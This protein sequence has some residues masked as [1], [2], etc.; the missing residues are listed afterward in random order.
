MASPLQPTPGLHSRQSHPPFKPTPT[1]T[2][3]PKSVTYVLE[4]KVLPMWLTGPPSDHG[5]RTTDH[6]PFPSR[7]PT[8]D[9]LRELAC[10]RALDLLAGLLGHLGPAASTFLDAAVGDSTAPTDLHHWAFEPV[11]DPAVPTTD[12]RWPRNPIDR[13]ILARLETEG[14]PSPRPPAPNGPARSPT[15]PGFRPTPGN[16]RPSSLPW[17]PDAEARVVDRLLASPGSW[18]TLG[19]A[20]AGRRPL[21]RHPWL[22][23]QTPERPN[24]WPT[25]ITSSAPSTTTPPT[26]GSLRNKFAETNSV[27]TPPRAS[28]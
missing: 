20:L 27:R 14:P 11:R 8:D 25:G 3:H 19:A 22:R 26:A 5:P 17:T 12:T 10:T 23:G 2:P 15:S 6:G 9:P 7:F 18:G 16:W 21:R 24:A 1:C 4:P 13:F 28:W